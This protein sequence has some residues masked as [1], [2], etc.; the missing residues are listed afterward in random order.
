VDGMKFQLCLVYIKYTVDTIAPA[1]TLII[2]QSLASATFPLKL[3]LSEI[4][5]IFKSG[6]ATDINNNQPMSVLSLFAKIF[7]NTI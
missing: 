5:P 4:N 6:I 1:L 2:N 3:K 7:E